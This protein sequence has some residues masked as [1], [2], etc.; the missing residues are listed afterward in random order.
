MSCSGCIDAGS[1]ISCIPLC[2]SGTSARTTLLLSNS[3]IGREP[4]A[5]TWNRI[6]RFPSNMYED[7][8]AKR[9]RWAFCQRVDQVSA[10]SVSRVSFK[11]CTWWKLVGCSQEAGLFRELAMQTD[12]L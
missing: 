5:A 10:I 1:G 6:S 12:S 8:A 3:Y 11:A 9:S 7:F 4:L 2:K